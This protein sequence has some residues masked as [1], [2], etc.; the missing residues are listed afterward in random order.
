MFMLMMHINMKRKNQY[1]LKFK[2]M[3]KYIYAIGRRKT[4]IATIRLFEGKEQSLVNDIAFEKYFVKEDNR[5]VVLEP[6]VLLHKQGQYYFTVKVSGGGKNAQAGA[7]R[8]ALARALVK[9][10]LE[11]KG[12]LKKAGMLTRDPR[13]KERKKT[14]LVKAR[15]APQFSKR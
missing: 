2:L 5:F 7:V 8:L 6:L 12:V 4:A 13:A 11:F 15:K 3:K 10:N 9:A 1:Q 14:G